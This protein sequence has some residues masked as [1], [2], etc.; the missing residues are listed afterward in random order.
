MRGPRRK[1][2]ISLIALFIIVL[3]GLIS[4]GIRKFLADTTP[5][6]IVIWTG[7]GSDATCGGEGTG[8]WWSCPYNWSGGVVPTAADHVVFDSTSV[9]NSTI[10]SA[11]TGT[12]HSVT[13]YHDYSGVVTQERDFNITHDFNQHGATFNS[14][15]SYKFDVSGSFFIADN[16]I[17]NGTIYAIRSDSAGKIYIGGTFQNISGLPIK[18]AAV[19]DGKKWSALGP[20]LDGDVASIAIDSNNKVYFGGKFRKAGVIDVNGIAMWDGSS[21]NDLDGGVTEGYGG[22]PVPGEVK[23]IQI[24]D[25]NRVYIGGT[26]ENAGSLQH[27][28]HIAR[29]NGSGWQRFNY[30]V[31]TTVFSGDNSNS[32]LSGYVNQILIKA[33][34]DPT[35]ADKDIYIGGS[36]TKI[37]GEDLCATGNTTG[38]YL[39]KY[40][41]KAGTI[42]SLNGL[43]SAPSSM[44]FDTQ[45]RLTVY[46]SNGVTSTA[47]STCSIGY[48]DDT[49]WR[50][51]PA[52]QGAIYKFSNID[53]VI[54]AGSSNNW[55]GSFMNYSIAI[56]GEPSNYNYYATGVVLGY[57]LNGNVYDIQKIG[58]DVYAVGSFSAAN[59]TWTPGS[60]PGNQTGSIV[61]YN[62][63]ETNQAKK[64]TSPFNR[65]LF[66]RFASGDG[67]TASPYLIGDVYGLQAASNYAEKSFS[68]AN[69]ID[70][71]LTTNW[72]NGSYFIPL[73]S[74][75]K[76][77]LGIFNGNNH[78]INNLKMGAFT[79]N[80]GLFGVIGK[81]GTVSDLTLSNAVLDSNI[82]RTNAGI[83]V[84]KNLGYIKNIKVQGSL[85]ITSTQ[86]VPGYNVGGVVGFTDN[87]DY[88][89]GDVVI[90]S[91]KDI[92]SNISMNCSYI[93]NIGGILGNQMRTSV[94]N[95]DTATESTLIIVYNNLVSSGTIT[96]LNTQGSIGGIIGRQD[97]EYGAVNNSH[98]S[99]AIG[100]NISD[101]TYLST[102]SADAVGGL[103]GYSFG[104]IVNSYA[105]GNVSLSSTINDFDLN[106]IG[107]LVG[108]STVVYASIPNVKDSYATGNI[109]ITQATGAVSQVGGLAG[110][111]VAGPV[112][113]SYSNGSLTINS[114]GE[115][116]SAGGLIG[117]VSQSLIDSNYSISN[118]S[119]N[120]DG[121]TG[122]YATGGFGGLIG[123]SSDNNILNSRA[124]GN[125]SI[126]GDPSCSTAGGVGGL[127]GI[128]SS[129]IGN[130]AYRVYARGK[131]ETN[132]IMV[133]G[134]FGS[135]SG[136]V[137][138]VFATGY[139]SGLNRVGG[140]IGQASGMNGSISN[141]FSLGAVNGE[142]RTGS[143]IGYAK[144]TQISKSYSGGNVTTTGVSGGLVGEID[145]KETSL[146]D[147]SEYGT[148]DFNNIWTNNT[149][150]PTPV[151]IFAK[152][153][154]P[155][156]GSI[157]APIL[158]ST[159][160]FTYFSS[161]VISGTKSDGTTKILVNNAEASISGNAWTKE[162]N[163]ALGQNTITVIGKDQANNSAASNTTIIRRK[164][165]DANND[166]TINIKDFS[167]LMMNWN[168]SESANQGDFNE[169]GKI[170]IL[171]FSILMS[172]WG[173]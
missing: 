76:P 17:S 113:G 22:T 151:L 50:C 12:V 164:S 27:T 99:V 59:T 83:L 38:N 100:I 137:D 41:G 173:K 136:F 86:S 145:L 165:A 147:N 101:P 79:Y 20:G 152:D 118:I 111:V 131:V 56:S 81:G 35:A 9:K 47:G 39:A 68:L 130:K 45:D 146:I 98:S 94:K 14:N 26:F 42:I 24:D 4:Y 31:G 112:T 55:P 2:Y 49:T 159:R 90:E 123:L 43:K 144:D 52:T 150:S 127:V 109:N 103:V 128:Y 115:V 70:A 114:N 75:K 82:F 1:I 161:I 124:T 5:A 167:L 10:D 126:S 11:F 102:R 32:F 54:Y 69:D 157:T 106:S 135:A 13:I 77:S 139:V 138:Q 72:N 129:Q 63:A 95:R 67:S 93:N 163:L 142:S 48:F 153:L 57:G 154:W 88:G 80:S 85:N 168:K 119:I 108:Y 73:S 36:F 64:L 120:N 66:N 28:N 33:N 148:W 18:N 143:L 58:N 37:C 96:V 84:G 34:S 3:V 116:K 172:N 110:T 74:E 71:T 6:P 125:L 87:G 155:N 65:A 25:Q 162:I 23:I 97:Y 166:G 78:S 21:W 51:H 61:R 170:N 156:T 121:A 30:G 91:L 53:N 105:T 89:T 149:S 160:S 8:N 60:G 19:F 46:S 62:P 141:T 16:Q 44:V 122:Q 15:P 134:L 132:C 140:L 169:D 107:S 158:N 104:S 40:D 7:I 133:G 29:W 92:E 117:Y 171:D